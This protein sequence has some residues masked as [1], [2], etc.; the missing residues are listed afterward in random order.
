MNTLA[1][2]GSYIGLSTRQRRDSRD[3]VLRDLAAFQSLVTKFCGGKTSSPDLTDAFFKEISVA[4]EAARRSLT[5]HSQSLGKHWLHDAEWILRA[6]ERAVER[7]YYAYLHPGPNPRQA[8][9]KAHQDYQ[10]FKD[11]FNKVRR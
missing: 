3:A 5:E 2:L 1:K 7:Y 9:E 10:R 8:M 11:L 4:K 6:G